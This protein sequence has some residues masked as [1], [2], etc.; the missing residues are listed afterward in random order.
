METNAQRSFELNISAEEAR[1]QVSRWLRDEVSLLISADPPTL[2]VGERV[3]WRVP[4][5]FRVPDLGRVGQVGSIDVDVSSG[6][7]RVTPELG[8]ELEQK[9]DEL[10]ERLPPYQP[11]GPVPEKYRPKHIP[12]APQITLD[13]D[14]LPAVASAPVQEA[15]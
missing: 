10:A 13:E 2:V 15:G 7:I 12:P 1:Q 6:T 14:G 4:A 3:V 5:V 11:K 8:R 9:A